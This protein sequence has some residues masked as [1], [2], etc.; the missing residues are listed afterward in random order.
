MD[1]QKLLVLIM[2]QRFSLI[3]KTFWN[4]FWCLWI[5]D[6]VEQEIEI[7]KVY[8][9]WRDLLQIIRKHNLGKAGDKF[10]FMC[11]SKNKELNLK[12]VLLY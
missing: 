10:V 2:L 7:L 9:Y 6:P 12:F 5:K 3:H 8:A 1:T 11:S 4:I